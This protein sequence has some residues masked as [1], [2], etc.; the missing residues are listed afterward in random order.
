[1][2]FIMFSCLIVATYIITPLLYAFGGSH[3]E[4]VELA[5]TVFKACDATVLLLGLAVINNYWSLHEHRARVWIPL[6]VT[7]D[8]IAFNSFIITPVIA[9]PSLSVDSGVIN[10][11]SSAS[12]TAAFTQWNTISAIIHLVV[13]FCCAWLI[14]C[15]FQSYE[16][17]YEKQ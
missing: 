4:S 17:T 15:G 11:V 14:Y 10:L 6:L 7:I 16:E 13:S 3:N 12:M 2:L 1:M 9:D 8:L 5:N